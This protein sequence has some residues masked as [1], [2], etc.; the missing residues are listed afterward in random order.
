MGLPELT[1]FGY[2]KTIIDWINEDVGLRVLDLVYW[3]RKTKLLFSSFR[4]I[5]CNHIYHEHNMTA[6]VLSKV[7]LPV[8]IGSLTL[9]EFMED[10]L[11]FEDTFNIFES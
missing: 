5:R 4:S 2:S 3:C 1:V 11:I 9:Q 10:V 7:A 6:D 8:P